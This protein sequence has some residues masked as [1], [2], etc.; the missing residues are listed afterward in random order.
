MKAILLLV[1]ILVTGL[2]ISNASAQTEITIEPNSDLFEQGQTVMI[3]GNT[4]EKATKQT[5]I[6]KRR[7]W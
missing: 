3:T 6:E 2:V 7:S 4:E 1:L 5:T